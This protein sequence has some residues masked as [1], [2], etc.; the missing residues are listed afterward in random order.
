MQFHEL[1]TVGDEFDL[2]AA[3]LQTAQLRLNDRDYRAGDVLILRRLL[4]VPVGVPE[5]APAVDPGLAPVLVRVLSVITHPA[6]G[7][8]AAPEWPEGWVMLCHKRVHL[9]PSA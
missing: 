6:L 8:W 1:K 4:D 2:I 9:E 5:E 3:G 7:W